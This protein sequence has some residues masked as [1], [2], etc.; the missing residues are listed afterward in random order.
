[1]EPNQRAADTFNSGQ[2]SH[3]LADAGNVLAMTHRVDQEAR[4]QRNEGN[5]QQ[6]AV[7]EI[8]SLE[9]FGVQALACGF[10]LKVEL[11]THFLPCALNVT[12]FDRVDSNPVTFINEWR[13]LDRHAVLERR[14]FINV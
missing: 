6:Q 3:P 11:S 4:H 8:H 13:N 1:M 10:N 7:D 2:L 5:G 14:R 9:W 12:P